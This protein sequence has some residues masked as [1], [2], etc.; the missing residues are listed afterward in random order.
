[1]IQVVHG[2]DV[3]SRLVFHFRDGSVDDD[4]T[5]MRQRRTFRV[6]SDHHVQKGPS[7]PKPLHMS[8]GA[9]KSEVTWKEF[10]DGKSKQKWS[11]SIYRTTWQTE[12]YFW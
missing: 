6:I 11:T 7:F 8:I 5:V 12:S 2:R 9:V 4:A 1:M 3:R 10:K